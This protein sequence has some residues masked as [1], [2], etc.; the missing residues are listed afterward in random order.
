[1]TETMLETQGTLQQTLGQSKGLRSILSDAV[2]GVVGVVVGVVV[3]VVVVAVVVV[4]VVEGA[5]TVV[6]NWSLQVASES[7]FEIHFKIFDTLIN[8]LG[9]PESQSAPFDI[10]TNV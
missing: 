1:M 10:P 8:R 9:F 5:V 2:G 4:I 3:V 6:K 7:F